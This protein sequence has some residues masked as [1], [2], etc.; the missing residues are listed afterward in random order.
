MAPQRDAHGGTSRRRD[1]SAVDRRTRCAGVRIVQSSRPMSMSA[2]V[3]SIASS[4]TVLLLALASACTDSSGGDSKGDGSASDG[5]DA[6]SS[7]SEASSPTTDAD[8]DSSG[9][10]ST[11][12]SGAGT[13]PTIVAV[14]PLDLAIDVPRNASVSA[15]FSEAMDA[16]ALTTSTFVVIAE[17]AAE[18]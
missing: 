4:P 15:V 11:G 12:D 7:A 2:R 18:P 16:D 9:D 13:I 8:S 3:L 14:D 1:G 10:A 6:S 5:A 17:D